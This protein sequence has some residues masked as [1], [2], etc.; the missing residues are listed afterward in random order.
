MT[1]WLPADFAKPQN[2]KLHS[3]ASLCE[4]QPMASAIC[5]RL[6]NTSWPE[7]AAVLKTT[8]YILGF[9][10]VLAKRRRSFK[11]RT[12][13]CHDLVQQSSSEASIFILSQLHYHGT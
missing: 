3:K 10:E 6:V 5:E 4:E 12:P 8:V 11:V 7:P 1:A 13:T 2:E 9:K